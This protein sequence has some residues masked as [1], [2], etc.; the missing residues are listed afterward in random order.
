[1]AWTRDLIRSKGGNEL[2]WVEV[3]ENHVIGHGA[4]DLQGGIM[5]TGYE[6]MWRWGCLSG[7]IPGIVAL[8]VLLWFLSSLLSMCGYGIGLVP[9]SE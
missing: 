9:E 6:R 5:S 1:M 8:G 2:Y 7:C 4:S 3:D